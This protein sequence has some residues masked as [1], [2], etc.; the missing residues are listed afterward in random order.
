[1]DVDLD[2][3][4]D[5]DVELV[6]RDRTVRIGELPIE[7]VRVDPDLE[8]AT[9]GLRLGHVLDPRQ[10]VEDEGSYGGE[11]QDGDA[12]PDQLELRRAVDLWPLF[13]AR[14]VAAAVLVD[15]PD[16]RA[17]DEHEDR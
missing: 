13:A 16:E 12:G 2:H 10:L 8:R 11:D 1:M 4:S 7:L 9:L 15:E 17:L 5:R 6:D 3:P 14:P